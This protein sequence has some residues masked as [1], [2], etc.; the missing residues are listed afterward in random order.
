MQR[1]LLLITLFLCLSLM[2]WFNFVVSSNDMDEHGVSGQEM[3]EGA[4]NMKMTK[5][6]EAIAGFREAADQNNAV[7]Y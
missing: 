1:I 4:E 5:V 3:E 7:S 2:L 6:D